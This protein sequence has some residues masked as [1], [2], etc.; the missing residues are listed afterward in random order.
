MKVLVIGAGNMGL[1]YAMAMAQ[2][3][4]LNGDPL[5][6]MD[7]SPERLKLLEGNP[8]F[9]TFDQIEKCIPLADVVLIAVKPYHA[10]ALFGSVKN[11]V[12]QDQ[13]FVSLMAGVS[14][15]SIQHGLGV[16]KVIRTM[17]NLPALVRKGI[18][19]YTASEQ[20]EKE[21]L[22]LVKSLLGT[23]GIAFEVD[24]EENV[25]ASTGISGS[26]PAYV[27]YF[28]ESMLEAAE[29]MGFSKEESDMLVRQT[30][31]GAI[32]LYNQNE[33]T[34]GEWMDRVASRGGTTRAALDSMENNGVKDSI[35]QAAFAAFHRAVEIGG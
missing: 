2:S 27:F 8:S 1:T 21:E 15:R 22:E 19:S 9:R 7:T 31:E 34:P 6:V 33:L 13:V 25:D 11:L 3:G 30:F 4:I 14:I 18:T 10:D 5:F 20:V 12:R 23:T 29:D 24:T 28:M 16:T 17:P 26:G 35:K 32:E